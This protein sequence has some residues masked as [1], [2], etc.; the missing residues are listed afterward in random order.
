MPPRQALR[1]L[2]LT[3]VLMYATFAVS[4][5]FGEAQVYALLDTLQGILGFGQ[6]AGPAPATAIWK[7]VAVGLIGTL[8]LM[9]WWTWLDV[10]RGRPLVQLMIYAKVIA[11]VAMIVH[12]AVAGEVVAF[13]LGGLSDLAMGAFALIF[14]ERAFPGA[15]RDVVSLRWPAST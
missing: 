6:P 4:V 1:M 2:M 3:Y 12:F 7:Y 5:L 8:A 10:D 15:W 9:S 13:L 11:G 14:L